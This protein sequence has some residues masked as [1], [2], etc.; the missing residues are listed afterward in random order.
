MLRRVSGAPL[1]TRRRTAPQRLRDRS[2]SAGMG[3]AEAGAIKWEARPA[4]VAPPGPGHAPEAVRWGVV[5][6]PSHRWIAFGD[7]ARCRRLVAHLT[8]ADAIF[9]GPNAGGPRR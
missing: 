8:E 5:H 7:E 9:G 2:G 6:V 4:I 3:T 1:R